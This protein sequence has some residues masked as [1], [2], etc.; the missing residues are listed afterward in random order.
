MKLEEMKERCQD[1]ACLIEGEDGEWVC[2][3]TGKRCI[4]IEKCPEL[5]SP[6]EVTEFFSSYKEESGNEPVRRMGTQ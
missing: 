1:C 5:V 2:D 4:D 3:E 6:A